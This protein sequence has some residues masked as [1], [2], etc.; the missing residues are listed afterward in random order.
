MIA[1]AA[2]LVAAAWLASQ[3]LTP[4]KR[5]APG[6]DVVVP[7]LISR[8]MAEADAHSF[9]RALAEA[10]HA[11]GFITPM[12]E[13][14]VHVPPDPGNPLNI[15]E[16]I[17]VFTARGAYRSSK[18]GSVF[19]FRHTRAP[20]DIIAALETPRLYAAGKV[21]FSS[22]LFGTVLPSLALRRVGGLPGR[23][24]GAG[25]ECPVDRIVSLRAGRATTIETLNSMVAQ[26]KGVGWLVRFGGPNDNQRLQIGYVCAN[27]VWSAL[28]VPGW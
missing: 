26:T 5:V 11:A 9:A 22:A 13:R 12:S 17:A 14:Q 7:G 28:S 4:P 25:P 6:S 3:V 19:V 27:G 10:G 8:A 16:A 2:T 18:Q 20:A 1:R 23:E 15:N 21:P 24:P